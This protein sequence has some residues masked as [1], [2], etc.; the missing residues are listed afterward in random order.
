MSEQQTTAQSASSTARGLTTQTASQGPE[1]R[2][3]YF[4]YNANGELTWWDGPRS[5]PEDYAWRDYDGA[6]RPI[7]EIRWRSRPRADGSA[8][9][10]ETGDDLYATTF[11]FYDRFGN[12]TNTM[13]SLGNYTRMQWDALGRMT[14]RF[15]SAA[16]GALLATNHFA[17]EPGGKVAVAINPLGGGTTNTYNVAGLL[18]ERWNADGSTNKWTFYADGR[19]KREYLPNASFWET[20]YLDSQRQVARCFYNAAG[21]LQAGSTNTFDARGN[22]IRRQDFNGFIFTST[23]DGLDRLK[24]AAGPTVNG[25]QQ[26]TTCIYDDAGAVFQSVNALNETNVV[27]K[28]A[29]GR[30]ISAAIYG[31]GT[32]GLVRY[33]ASAYAADHNSVISV[34]GW[35]AGS[36]V[37]TVYTDTFGR[38]VLNVSPIPGQFSLNAYDRLGRLILTRNDLAQTTKLAYDGLGRR[39]RTEMPDGAVNTADYDPAG[40][41]LTNTLPGNLKTITLYDK[42]SRPITNWLQGGGATANAYGY[43]YYATGAVGLLASVRDGRGLVRTNSYDAWQRLQQQTWGSLSFAMQYDNLGRMTV[44]EQTGSG[45]DYTR[46]NRTFDAYGQMTEE[47]V[48]TAGPSLFSDFTQTWDAAGRRTGLAGGAAAWVFGYRADGLLAHVGAFG[49]SYDYTYQNNGLLSQRS[50]PDRTWSASQRDARGRLL[51][52]ATSVGANNV[53]VETMHWRANS[54][55]NDYSANRTGTGTWN[56]TRNYSYNTRGQLTGETLKPSASATLA[57]VYGYDTNKLGVLTAAGFVGTFTNAWDAPSSQP[58][59]LGRVAQEEWS[60]GQWERWTRGRALGASNVN[61]TLDGQAVSEV[62][63]DRYQPQG[64]WEARLDFGAGSHTLRA[65]AYHPSGLFTVNTTNTFTAPASVTMTAQ[66]DGEGNVTNRS[67]SGGQVQNLLWDPA[68][69]LASVTEKNG[70]ATNWTWRAI[71][72]SLGRRLQTTFRP[73]ALNSQPSTINQFYDPQV[74]F[75]ET[76]ISYNG[77]RTWKVHGPDLNDLYGGLKGVGGLEATVAEADGTRISIVSDIFGHGAAT[78]SGGVVKWAVTPLAGY[79]PLVGFNPPLLSDYQSLA[80]VSLYRGKRIDPTG[81]YWLGARYYEPRAGRF[82]SPDP[83]GHAGSWDLYSF[84]N[85]DPVG[86]FDPDGRMA[87]RSTQTG[88]QN[89][90]P[91]WELGVAPYMRSYIETEYIYNDGSRTGF[92]PPSQR[93]VSFPEDLA[94]QRYQVV[95]EP[96]DQYFFYVRDANAGGPLADDNYGIRTVRPVTT[97]DVEQQQR[98][99]YLKTVAVFAA[100]DLGGTFLEATAARLLGAETAPAALSPAQINFSQRTVAANVEQYTADMLNKEWDWSRSGPIRAMQQEGQW[101]SYDNRRLMAAQNAGLRA[102][103]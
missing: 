10:A 32:A 82:L 56:E 37:N 60:V 48:W 81:F 65:A 5:N 6:G 38:P 57:G 7:T 25:V 45:T 53:L 89:A 75:L 84:A 34:S 28:D 8:V 74:E 41:V 4:Y 83:V 39:V 94:V 78:A 24:S 46:V 30:V 55:L 67:L 3:K 90:P 73:G 88:T 103:Q 27:T 14:D 47:A 52:S 64:T 69:R 22:L 72:D 58:D 33:S 87:N 92:L 68:G 51:Q 95:T 61:A 36:L 97:T 54:T 18:V 59:V 9:E 1:Y 80:E 76:G 42:A 2:T 15:S 91:P 29:L 71:Y 20:T 98:L 50:T 96:T 102:R 40:N 21:A 44:L 17:Y 23:F 85:G 35:S 79:G 43:T 77:A 99:E 16:S 70:S 100:V 11:H 62:R 12:E 49:Q 63:F 93:V 19:P 86:S 26:T 13:D 66:Y 101:V 31:A